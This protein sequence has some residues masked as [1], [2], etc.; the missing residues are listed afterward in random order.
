MLA[1]LGEE[2]RKMIFSRAKFEKIT[3]ST[4]TKDQ[5]RKEL[6]SI[7]ARGYSETVGGMYDGVCARSWRSCVRRWRRVEMLDVDRRAGTP[8]DGQQGEN[9]RR[10]VAG[11]QRNVEGSRI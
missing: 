5:L 1:Y 9:C 8:R 7:R 10:S 3:P 2:V 4:L 11:R 6:P